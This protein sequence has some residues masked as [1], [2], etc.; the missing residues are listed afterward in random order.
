MPHPWQ[1]I[2]SAFPTGSFAHSGGLEAA[3]QG[4]EIVNDAA[5]DRFVRD[6]LWQAGHGALPLLSPA[7]RRPERLQEIDAIADAFLTNAVA[8]RASRAQGRAFAIACVRVWP[9]AD[10]AGVEEVTRRG[11]G[12]AAPVMGAALRALDVPLATAQ[13]MYLYGVARNA[14]AAAVRLGAVGP[15]RAQQLQHESIGVQRAVIDAC[16]DLDVA[17]LAQTSPIVDVFQSVHDRLYSRL[18]QS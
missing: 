12:H 3:W 4:G 7:H 15:Y 11:C 17:D 10:L 5:L 13:Q 6:S 2:D 16:A 14:L 1:L 18:F 8:N 9:S